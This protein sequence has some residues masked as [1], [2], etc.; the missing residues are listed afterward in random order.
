MRL[1]PSTTAGRQGVPP[2]NM[3]MH[4]FRYVRRVMAKELYAGGF[5]HDSIPQDGALIVL[6]ENGIDALDRLL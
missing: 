4:L 1:Q 2:E 3:M 5:L 6:Y